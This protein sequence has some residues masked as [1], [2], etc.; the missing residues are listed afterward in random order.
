VGSAPTIVPDGFAMKMPEQGRRR[1]MA[2]GLMSGTSMDGVDAALVEIEYS[3]ERVTPQLVAAHTTE[4]PADILA[5]L[6]DLS[7]LAVDDIARLNF[8][9]G[10]VF[11]KAAVDVIDQGGMSPEQIDVIGSHGQTVSH[12]PRSL[13]GPGVTLQLGEPAVIAERTGVV[14]VADFRVND[15][16]A[17]G[18]GAPLVPY[19]DWLLFAGEGRTVAA[20]NIGGIANVTVVTER[21]EDVI[22]FDTGP[23]NML[24][25]QAVALDTD[26]AARFDRDGALADRGTVATPLLDHLMVHPYLLK[27]PPKSS[28]A[29]EF[30]AEFV[31]GLRD[32]FAS[33]STEDFVAT[34]TEFTAR[35]IADGYQRFVYPRT[36]I[37][38]MVLSGGGARNPS[39]RRRIEEQL[40]PVPVTTSDAYGIDPDAK[41]AIS[42]AVLAVET[43]LLRPAN[44]PQ[45]TG[46]RRPVILGKIV[47]IQ[48]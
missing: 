25:D 20:Q 39:L 10:E 13:G 6:N 17:G 46:A 29:A 41:E 1:W 38:E 30:G 32:Q 5:S 27:R 23:G 9:I 16:A 43:M 2:V 22:A 21:I 15:V 26:G 11:A 35:S 36:S 18:D 37:D 42:F 19:V 8:Q 34:L 45:A 33:V 12:Q 4:Y 44:V 24:I 47:P 3:D 7:A 31:A 40:A 48:G 14:T 28:G